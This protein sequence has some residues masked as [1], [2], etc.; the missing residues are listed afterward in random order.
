MAYINC[1][2]DSGSGAPESIIISNSSSYN[3]NNNT[4]TGN[5]WGTVTIPTMGYRY[6][7]ID[8]SNSSVGIGSNIDISG[9]NKISVEC[10]YL[11][12]SY[13]HM[14]P[15]GTWGHWYGGGHESYSV[16]LHN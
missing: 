13:H 7:D 8:A 16:V 10:S 5:G 3:A 2:V 14:N 9:V 4:H 15:D 1:A 6:A 12:G 11:I